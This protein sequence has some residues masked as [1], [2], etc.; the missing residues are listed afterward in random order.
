MDEELQGKLKELFGIPHKLIP[1]LRYQCQELIKKSKGGIH[2]EDIHKLVIHIFNSDYYPLI[3]RNIKIDDN[4][5]TII[6]GG[7]AFNMNVPPKM[8][9]LKLDTDDFDLKIYTTDI[10]YKYNHEKGKNNSESISKVISV[11]K[12]S[13][14]IICMYLKQ[15][16]K[17][18][19][20]YD[21]HN[22]HSYKTKYNNKSKKHDR[23]TKKHLMIKAN[24]GSRQLII[25]KYELILQIKKKDD[26]TKIY[27][28]IDTIDFSVMSYIEIY[29]RVI[30]SINHPE[31]L[32]TNKISYETNKVNKFRPLTFSDCKIIYA[33]LDAPAF[34]GQYFEANQHEL[35]KSL[36]ELIDMHIPINKI[37]D[38]KNCANKC[39][40]MSLKSLIIDTILM[41]SY[42]DL[43]AY[44]KIESGGQV[45]VPAS[46]IFKYYKYLVKFIRLMVIKKY[47]SGT[48]KGQFFES[49]KALWQ[50]ALID[51]R[52][53]AANLKPT[54]DEYDKIN[55]I[56]KNFLNEFHQNLFH[57]RSILTSKYPELIDIANEYENIVFYINKSR[58][59]FK[60]L[61][62]KSKSQYTNAVETIESVAI[63]YAQKEISKHESRSRTYD[64]DLV[65]GGSGSKLKTINKHISKSVSLTAEN[66]NY[67]DLE[68]DNPQEEIKVRVI[69]NKLRKMITDEVSFYTKNL[70]T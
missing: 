30:E 4:N 69:L 12:F 27:Q 37:I 55:I 54:L 47:Y 61:N 8:A 36:N 43:L 41:L 7:I 24:G 46:F 62:D 51:L 45:L 25:G 64:V 31:L 16:F 53:K 34:F 58:N 9:F 17:F 35:N 59:L 15:I 23:K 5:I 40:F 28:T 42:A 1:K 22:K 49:A 56:Y 48:L 3:S 63:Q 10:N 57:N 60:E 6:M 14:L 66:Y 67:D 52:R 26:E 20:T 65:T 2:Y 33:G 50:Y 19:N 29:S 38:I 70:L 11:F 32:I 39:R 18:L 13:I 68:L 44:E 21:P